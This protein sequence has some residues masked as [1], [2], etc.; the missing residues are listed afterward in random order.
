MVSPEDQAVSLVLQPGAE[1][2]PL[3][4]EFAGASGDRREIARL[5]D[6]AARF[7]FERERRGAVCTDMAPVKLRSQVAG[8]LSRG[9][10]GP[11]SAAAR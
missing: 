3:G 7:K 9:V 10:I 8:A 11:R 6:V 5:L 4:D 2:T 1:Q